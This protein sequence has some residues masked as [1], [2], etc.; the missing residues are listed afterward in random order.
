[1]KYIVSFQIEM[2]ASDDS[3]AKEKMDAIMELTK[4][5]EVLELGDAIGCQI[6]VKSKLVEESG[7]ILREV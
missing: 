1:M 7:C 5:N 3:E 2:D 6:R 4:I